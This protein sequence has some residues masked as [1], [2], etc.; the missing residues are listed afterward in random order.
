M[1]VTGNASSQVT[2]DTQIQGEGSTYTYI[3]TEANG[4]KEVF[5]TD[6]PGQYQVKLEA[7]PQVFSDDSPEPSPQPTVEPSLEPSPS[8]QPQEVNQPRWQ[9][10]LSR[11]REK[12][13][14]LLSKFRGGD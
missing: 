2:V 3:E 6:Q 4:Q 12:V 13:N 5:E 1:I 7:S 11:I 14:L 10:F 8:P 9:T